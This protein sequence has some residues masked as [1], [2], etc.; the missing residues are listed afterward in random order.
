MARLH[1]AW[2]LSEILNA[3]RLDPFI[4]EGEAKRAARYQAL[5]A[6][7]REYE[8]V[9]GEI[10]QEGETLYPPQVDPL[11][12]SQESKKAPELYYLID[13][14]S[15]GITRAHQGWQAA[16]RIRGTIDGEEEVIIE[17][18][19]GL[20]FEE[21]GDVTPYGPETKGTDVALWGSLTDFRIP[22]GTPYL[23]LIA[24][25]AAAAAGAT[26]EASEASQSQQDSLLSP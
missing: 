18:S 12:V 13:K 24:A 10:V 7:N 3:I 20:L 22:D 21:P 14:I 4:R 11:Y 15:E 17:A 19:S 23:P 16:T 26:E 8:N 2:A 1:K 6:R 25:L 9:Y 5:Q